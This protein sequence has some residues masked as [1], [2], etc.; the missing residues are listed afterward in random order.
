MTSRGSK[1]I[2]AF[3]N[4]LTHFGR[5]KV[6]V[7]CLLVLDGAILHLVHSTVERRDRMALQ[8]RL[9]MN[10][11]LWTNLSLDHLRIPGTKR[12]CCFIAKAQNAL[13]PSRDLARFLLKHRIKQP[14][15]PTLKLRAT[16]I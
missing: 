1:I 2:E 11:N 10:C 5:Y 14:H 6:A 3:V 16:G 13:S 15:Q 12:V 8:V 9:H 4:W 7:S